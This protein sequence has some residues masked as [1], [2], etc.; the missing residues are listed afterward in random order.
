MK[1]GVTSTDIAGKEKHTF[2]IEPPQVL[3]LNKLEPRELQDVS[4]SLSYIA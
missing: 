4:L 3:V 2:A 1:D